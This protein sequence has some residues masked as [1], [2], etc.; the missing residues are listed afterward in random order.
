MISLE[1][2]FLQ[3]FNLFRKV[4]HICVTELKQPTQVKSMLNG[5]SLATLTASLFSN[6][7]I[8]QMRQR[9]VM[10]VRESLSQAI[11][12]ILKAIP[13]P[14]PPPPPQPLQQPAVEFPMLKGPLSQ[15]FQQF[16]SYAT[17]NSNIANELLG[18]DVG[19]VSVCKNDISLRFE[20]KD[21]KIWLNEYNRR[22][23][24]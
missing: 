3:E 18:A 20:Q 14:Q 16:S 19:K 6:Q 12:H 4:S 9:T 7:Y 22:Q 5:E 11:G 21:N 13:K 15:V 8:D 17:N 1:S 23:T 10:E 2:I 24:L